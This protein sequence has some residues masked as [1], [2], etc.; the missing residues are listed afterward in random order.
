MRSRES[1]LNSHSLRSTFSLLSPPSHLNV[2]SQISQDP[3]VS[4][5]LRGKPPRDH[6]LRI[7]A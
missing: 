2:V 6:G 4:I 3:Y 1:K 7:R 5:V